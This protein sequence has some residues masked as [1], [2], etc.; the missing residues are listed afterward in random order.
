MFVGG[1]S[2]ACP[3]TLRRIVP[4]G[5]PEWCRRGGIGQD[6]IGVQAGLGAPELQRGDAVECVGEML[7]RLAVFEACKAVPAHF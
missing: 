1:Q 3:T 5:G 4:A 7:D 2:R 6:Q